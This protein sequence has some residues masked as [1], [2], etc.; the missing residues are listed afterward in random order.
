V[1]RISPLRAQQRRARRVHA[2][3]AI[4][5][6]IRTAT[7]NPGMNFARHLRLLMLG[8]AM[9]AAFWLAGWPDYYQQYAPLTLTLGCILLTTA[10]GVV[11]VAVLA[12]SA[13]RWRRTNAFWIA[14]YFTVPFAILDSLY[15]GWYLGHG[16]SYLGT[17]WYLTIFYLTPW[18]QFPPTA[19]LLDAMRRPDGAPHTLPRQEPGP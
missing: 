7:A 11:A 1:D 18:L 13:A 8:C 4:G 10:F 14:F 16:W 19:R 6:A 2:Q 12:R 17:Y 15:C 3:G 5:S 9:W